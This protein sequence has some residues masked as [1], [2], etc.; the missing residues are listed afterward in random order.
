MDELNRSNGNEKQKK[1]NSDSCFGQT[2]SHG[3]IESRLK[4]IKKIKRKD[5]SKDLQREY[6]T[7]MQQTHRG[8]KLNGINKENEIFKGIAI[9]CDQDDFREKEFTKDLLSSDVGSIWE[10]KNQC[11]F[12]GAYRFKDERNFC[13]GKGKVKVPVLKDPPEKM[14]K[15][16][17]KESVLKN[18]RGYNNI[19]AMASVGC[20]TPQEFK[21]P[22]FKIQGKVHHKIGSLIPSERN[23]PKFLQ[24]YFYDTDE[25]TQHRLDLMPKLSE[26]ILKEL[27]D[28][29]KETNCYVKSFKSAYELVNDETELKIFL[30]SDESKIPTGQ[31]S[32]K[33][34]LPQGCE[35]AAL[36]PGEGDGELEVLVK[37][38]DNRLMQ[39]NALHR[40]YDAL[41]YVLIDPYG[42][43]GFHTALGKKEGTS[44][45]ISIAEFYSFRIQVRS[46]FNQL[47]KSRRCFQQYLVDQASKIENARMKWVLDHQKTIKAEKYNGLLDASS[48]GDLA[49]V[50]VKIILPPTITGSPRF[51][52][53]KFQDAMAI[54]RKFGKPTLFIT[55]TCNPEWPEI[56]DA[57]YP[58]ET[59]FDRPDITTRVFKL[60]ND[61]LLDYIEKK[62][63]FG[64]VVAF[65]GT[66]EQ[67]KRKGLHHT[68]T[69]ITLES[70]PRN[71]E[72]VDKMISA[73]IPDKDLN[74]DLFEIIV[75]NNIHG[76]CG[77][78]NM[79][80]PCME[81]DDRGRK[82]CSKE[83]PKDFQEKTNLT[84]HTYPKYRRRGPAEGG[85]TAVK[86]VKGK[87]IVVDNSMV[88][89]Y[90]SFLSKKFGAHINVE[91]CESVVAVKYVYK[92]ITKG[93]D[94]CLMSTRVGEGG[95]QI[96]V[97]NVNE[98]QQ[99]VDARYL[100]A[101][102]AV[103]K[104]LRLPVHYRSHSV[105]KLPCHL[106][107]EQSVFFNE[108][109]E[110]IALKDGPPETKLTAFFKTNLEDIKAKELL[111]TDFPGHFGWR[112]GVWNRKKRAIG[113]A[114]GR[115]PTVSLCSKQM[116]TYALRV[117]LHHVRG[118]TC[119]DDLKTVNGVLMETF[120]KACQVLGL[121]EDDSEVQKALSE[122]C[123]IRFGDQL[124]A[125]FGSILEF[126]RPGSPLSLWEKF[127]AELMHHSQHTAGISFEEA[128]SRVLQQLKEQLNRSGSDLKDFNLPEPNNIS[129]SKTPNLILSETNFDKKELLIR[130]ESNTTKMNPEQRNFYESV[131]RSVSDKTGGLFCLNAA[132]GTGKTFTLNTLLDKVRGEGFV[133]LATASSGV[134]SKLLHNGTTVHSRFKVPINI[135]P[136]ST[137]SFR[138]TDATGKL[139]KE[140]KLIIMDE[141]TMLHRHVFEAVDR[142]L[143]SLTGKDQ[144]FGGITTAFSGDWRQC[145][146]IVKRG[147]RADVIHACLK[148]S[149]LWQEIQ[150]INLVRN[151]RVQLK[152]E[153]SEFSDLLLEI[154]NG[155]LK[156]NPNLGEA[157][158]EL[159]HEMFIKSSSP[160]DLITEVFCNFAENSGDIN[161]LRSRA[162]LC[163]T[164]EECGEINKILLDKLPGEKV[165]YKSCDTVN[166]SE[167]HMYPTEFLNTI[168]LQGIPPHCLELKPGAV[169]ILLRNLN[170]TEGHVNGTRYVVQNL[171]PHVIDAV[172]ISGSS[173]GAKIFIPRIWLHSQDAILPFEM[174]RKQFPVKLAYS[175]TANKAQ[176]Q[177]LESVGIYIAREFFSHG[178][179]YVAIS[180]VGNPESVKILFKK[181]NSF[182]VRNIVYREILN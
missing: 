141:M 5:R 68:H 41:S 112:A 80:S 92:Y 169:I 146:P 135:Q 162:I 144:P 40:S 118:P 120:Q 178:Q 16:F 55:M 104:I 91:F 159:P 84:E 11:K 131:M 129:R 160:I 167:A 134:A 161:W 4:E 179:F 79:N 114:I 153:S 29:I 65:V 126:C 127:K 25:A 10:S 96:E 47:I 45:N 102:E 110:E 33:Y 111:Y 164:N 173:V 106:P 43:D 3:E 130:A 66:Q 116:E 86:M 42:S 21:G 88:V 172:A 81:T 175:M 170:P 142:S 100:G 34:N 94:R 52:I 109:D 177:T 148:S 58:G 69:L 137:C 132:G 136:T 89:P 22:N 78:L 166:Q 57:L 62:E 180:R 28:I 171:L 71:P 149:K 39:I 124:I 97:E 165:V 30:V 150:V 32:G 122:A 90:N 145:L 50:G 37:D 19:L 17:E 154:G 85:R 152:G 125:F 67:Q 64:K 31:H 76:P 82:F 181:E 6:N 133:A 87:Q 95:E 13:C 121:L 46:G 158:V 138:S 59:A 7:L 176:G 163:P 101:S 26:E 108:G 156:E 15:L 23:S 107:N 139:I 151:M 128:E 12:C 70:V 75:K 168:D 72:D 1:I 147:S 77:K 115:I 73:E 60:K 48:T 44:R 117:L 143:R 27:T 182:H 2:I 98:V 56:Q 155:A 140:A 36:M 8:H 105:E 18:A 61:M 99:F 119:F 53:E 113:Q 63:I 24:L 174:K 9:K 49:N 93:P 14:R 74:P 123:S 157:M 83:F 35:V 54:A 51:Y 20:K 103:L 38:R